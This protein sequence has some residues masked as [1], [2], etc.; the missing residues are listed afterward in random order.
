MRFL[1]PLVAAL[2]P[3]L[4]TPGLLSYFDV[5]PKIAILLFGVSLILLYP[6]GTWRDIRT[7]WSA[8]AGRYFAVL[9]AAAWL[10]C[11]VA[12]TFS[13]YPPLSVHGGTWRRFGL[14]STTGL[15]L[16]AFAAAAWLA[17]DRKNVLTLLR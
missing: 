11:F 13:R 8:R 9:L 3:L 16:F 17:A 12:T 7:L 4:I 15:L 10:S 6:R 1:V 5:T 2:V 14:L